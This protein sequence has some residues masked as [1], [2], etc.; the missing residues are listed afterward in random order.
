MF[1]WPTDAGTLKFKKSSGGRKSQLQR[2]RKFHTSHLLDESTQRSLITNTAVDNCVTWT[3]RTKTEVWS[4]VKAM[5]LTIWKRLICWRRL[6]IYGGWIEPALDD[7]GTEVLIEW[8]PAVRKSKTIDESM[9]NWK[10]ERSIYYNFIK[11]VDRFSL[12]S[13]K[14]FELTRIDNRNNCISAIALPT[15]KKM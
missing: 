13:N 6:Q 8:I 15:V 14:K 1:W 9:M 7:N 4:Q 3:Y 10:S 11:N 2:D 12:T 5:F